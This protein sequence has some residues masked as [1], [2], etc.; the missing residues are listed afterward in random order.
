ME[1]SDQRFQGSVYHPRG[2]TLTTL[3]YDIRPRTLQNDYR[4]IAI[5]IRG[6]GASGHPGDAQSSST[7]GEFVDD[8]ACVLK[9]AKVAGKSV[10]IGSVYLFSQVDLY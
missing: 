7:M 2:P 5:D 6:M 3:M 9:H 10:C 8:L 1:A 4:V